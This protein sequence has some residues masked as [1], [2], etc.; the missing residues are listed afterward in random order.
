MKSLFAKSLITALAGL[1]TAG[2]AAVAGTY[3][4]DTV[5]PYLPVRTE[6]VYRPGAVFTYSPVTPTVTYYAPPAIAYP[7]QR[8]S[9]SIGPARILRR[10]RWSTRPCTI[11][12]CTI[13]RAV[14]VVRPKVYVRGQPVRN[15]LRRDAVT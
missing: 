10:R 13:R 4:I 12:P 5:Q 15:V 8:R 1:L 14:V 7:A 9:C 11:R 2:S 6:V 3:R